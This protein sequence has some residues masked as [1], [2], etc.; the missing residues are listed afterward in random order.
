MKLFKQSFEYTINVPLFTDTPSQVTK[1][2]L[3]TP[4]CK[5]L[6]ITVYA[7]LSITSP[8]YLKSIIDHAV[9]VQLCIMINSSLCLIKM[10]KWQHKH[11]QSE[12]LKLISTPNWSAA[13]SAENLMSILWF[14]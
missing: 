8:L 4:C 13:G 5:L 6:L 1:I 10:L 9:V 12:T 11:I 14:P 3:L 7:K 2:K